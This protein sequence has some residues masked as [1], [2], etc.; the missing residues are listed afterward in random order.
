MNLLLLSYV[1]SH[2]FLPFFHS[3]CLTPSAVS[4]GP[5][6]ILSSSLSPCNSCLFSPAWLL[7]I[8]LLYQPPWHVFTQSKH[9]SAS[10]NKFLAY[11]YSFIWPQPPEFDLPMWTFHIRELRHCVAFL[12][13]LLPFNTIF[14]VQ[15]VRSFWCAL[16]GWKCFVKG[17][18]LGTK[19]HTVPDF[20][21]LKCPH[22]HVSGAHYVLTCSANPLQNYILCNV[23]V[24]R[25]GTMDCLY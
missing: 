20:L 3:V 12:P 23:L 15:K 2:G 5:G 19:G 21:G 10:L 16:Q 24:I 17:D 18:K 11:L 22:W 13:Q 7:A 25:C 14:Q 9:I 4:H 6:F 8:Q 1:P